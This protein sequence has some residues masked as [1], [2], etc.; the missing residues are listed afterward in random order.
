MD[1]KRRSASVDNSQMLRQKSLLP[2]NPAEQP[3]SAADN[4]EVIDVTSRVT[5]HEIWIS[6]G[7]DYW[8]RPDQAPLTHG[9]QQ[10]SSVQCLPHRGLQGDRYANKKPGHKAQV[11]FFDLAVLQSLATKLNRPAMTLELT[12][13]NVLIE[14][15]DLAAWL[16]RRFRIGDVVFEGSQDCRPCK[17]MDQQ[18]GP[19]A[20]DMLKAPC[21]G[22]LRCRIL[23]AGQ[24]RCG[25]AQLR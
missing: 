7:H 9:C 25:D 19:G 20:T 16:H 8:V 12:R 13:R 22:G 3:L 1:P 5:I 23:T 15:L 6:P 17:W 18:I 10:V 2:E 24:L 11:T 14:G 21:H 4:L